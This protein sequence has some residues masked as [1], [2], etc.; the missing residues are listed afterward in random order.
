MRPTKTH[1]LPSLLQLECMSLGNIYPVKVL[2]R[3]STI[4]HMQT[5]R[6]SKELMRED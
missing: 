5:E 3:E 6:L 2:Q 1:K 4:K